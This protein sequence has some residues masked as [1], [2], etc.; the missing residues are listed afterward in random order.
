MSKAQSVGGLIV[1]TAAMLFARLGSAQELVQGQKP[2]PSVDD[3]AA[4]LKQPLASVFAKFGAPVDVFVTGAKSKDPGVI[5]DYGKF[6]F[7]I[8]DKKVTNCNFWAEW[9]GVVFGAKIGDGPDDMVKAMGKPAEDIKNADGTEMMTWHASDKKFNIS[10]TFTKKHIS[11][12]V[13]IE[14]E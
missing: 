10:V 14:P 2:L 4:M 7:E 6:G 9:P 5:A 13:I 12:G 8:H 3:V 11:D 1:L